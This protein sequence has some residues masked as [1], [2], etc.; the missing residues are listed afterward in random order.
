MN[1]SSAEA[2]DFLCELL[3]K[4]AEMEIENE[5]RRDREAP[6]PS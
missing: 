2:L 6:R 4:L 1:M 3:D 5:T